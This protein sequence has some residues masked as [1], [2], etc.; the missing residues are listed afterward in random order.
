MVKSGLSQYDVRHLIV[1][2]RRGSHY[3]R[4]NVDPAPKKGYS[5]K[6]VN[7]YLESTQ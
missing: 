7:R 2:D 6:V 5:G 1:L 3:Y 4:A